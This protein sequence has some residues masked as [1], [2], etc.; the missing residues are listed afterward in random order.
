M[1]KK[2]SVV[3]GFA[4]SISGFLIAALLNALI[5]ITADVEIV[6]YS[7]AGITV[8]INS[9]YRFVLLALSV[10]F[11][12][13]GLISIKDHDRWKKYVKGAPIRFASGIALLVWDILG[14]KW[15]LLPQPFFP[16]PAGIVEAFLIEP[17]F[18]L[19][20]TL[21]QCADSEKPADHG[22]LPQ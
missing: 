4:L 19:E 3:Y 8:D 14:T 15:Q 22:T 10:I 6:D 7:V 1:I 13:S 11:L 9:T 5:P 2:S 21:G 12:V 20:N 17:E 18:V 16:G